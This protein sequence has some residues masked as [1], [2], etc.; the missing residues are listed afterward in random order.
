MWKRLLVHLTTTLSPTRISPANIVIYSDMPETIGP[1]TVV[2]VFAN[3]SSSV[4]E[5]PDFEHYR[6]QPEYQAHNAYVEAAGVEG[7]DWGPPGGWV[8]DKYKFV[9]LMQHAGEHWPDVKWYVYMEDDTYLFL[10]SVRRYL[11]HFD[12]RESHY[13]GSYA[14]KTGVVFAHGG[15]GFALS[16]GA[17]EAS[18][19]APPKNGESSPSPD[20]TASKGRLEE[21]YHQYT[22]DH[23]CGDQVLA[24]ALADHGVQF[25][26]NGGDGK[27]TW[28]FNP[29]V[30]WAFA[31]S[32]YNWCS[33]L[34][35]WHKVHNR[36]V[37]QYYEFEKSWDFSVSMVSFP[38]SFVCLAWLLTLLET[39]ST[40]RLLHKH[41]PPP[42]PVPRPVVGQP[43]L[44]LRSHLRQ[45]GLGAHA[46]GQGHI[47]PGDV[48]DGLG[49]GRGVRGG[50]SRVGGLRELDVCGGSV[51]DG[52]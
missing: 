21:T 5:S 25:G 49:V 35:S 33:P 45:S 52:R 15:A 32:R 11:A 17:W 51:P 23:C 41:D 31:F 28:G 10:P 7:D 46:R 18:F 42:D 20:M 48:D 8:I 37:A 14:A 6:L 43:R 40:P 13:L 2:D 1:F 50:V 27:F 30:H 22:A 44:P 29:L 26:E 38:F 12:W 24:K 36:D 4:K 39:S 3:L 47:P 9:P 16:R 34:M 19:G